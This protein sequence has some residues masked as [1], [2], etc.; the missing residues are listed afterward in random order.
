M[1]KLYVV[2]AY[3]QIYSGMHGMEDWFVT[4]ADDLDDVE[5]EAR[6]A[7]FDVIASYGEIYESFESDAELNG[8]E[9]GTDEW[10]AF[11]EES[12]HEDVAYDIWEVMT[13]KYTFDEIDEFLSRDPDGFV[14]EYCQPVEY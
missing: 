10:E 4:D 3:E 12:E 1:S 7:S 14:D 5:E 2:R 9:E 11:I 8:L 6:E 13:D